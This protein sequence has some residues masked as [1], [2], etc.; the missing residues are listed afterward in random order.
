MYILITEKEAAKQLCLTQS[1]L[2]K[3]RW[4]GKGPSFIKIGAAV[5]YDPEAIKRFI[6]SNIQQSRYGI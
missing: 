6:T 4:L 2:R 1:T 3:W 5:R